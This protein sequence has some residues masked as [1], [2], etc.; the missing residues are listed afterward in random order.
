[1]PA[2][3]NC[4]SEVVRN[5]CAQC[6]QRTRRTQTIREFVRDNFE[7]QLTVDRKLP[8]TLAAL[9]LKPGLLTREYMAGRI[10]RY[11][12]PFRLYLFAS[13]LFFILLS[14]L[15]TRSEW[16]RLTGQDV[17]AE[18]RDTL[19]QA[20]PDS[21]GLN[22][23]LTVGERAWLDTTNLQVNTGSGWLDEKVRRNLTLLS[24]LPPGTAMQRV[25]TT[26]IEELPKVMFL[27]LPVYA[28]LLKLIYARRRRLYVEHFVFALH[29]HAYSFFLFVIALIVQRS[30][31]FALVCGVI[32]LHTLFAM[33]RVY[34]QGWFRT[35]VKWG[36]LG[37][38]YSILLSLGVTAALIWALAAVPV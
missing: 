5:Y 21:G 3:P 14:F 28:L 10:A 18:S 37:F 8:R 9:F 25:T 33:K 20:S 2:C 11:I 13:V 31:L 6:G 26:M 36:A 12:P 7:D 27:L 23:R 22:L 34:E 1:M 16:F 24:Q 35:L 30:W 19:A 38:M 4:G 29:L 32:A 17:L 15:S